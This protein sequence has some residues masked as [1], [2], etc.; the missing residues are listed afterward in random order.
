[1]K[2]WKYD[3]HIFIILIILLCFSFQTIAFSALSTT[4]N[5][6]G[7]GYARMKTDVRIT[8]VLLKNVNDATTNYDEF[9]KNTISTGITLNNNTSSVV[10]TIE[11]SNY[12][13]NSVGIYSI[14]GLPEGLSYS[15]SSDYM[16]GEDVLINGVGKT[17]FSLTISGAAGSY[18]FILD[19]DFRSRYSITYNGFSSKGYFPYIFEIRNSKLL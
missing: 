15:I 14:S 12:N 11:V 4:M 6:D 3:K 10:Y 17:S 16:V 5:I 13:S 2:N 7:V 9:S 8:D 19:L 1:M 18:D